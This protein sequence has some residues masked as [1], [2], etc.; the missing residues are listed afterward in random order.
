MQGRPTSETKKVFSHSRGPS[1]GFVATQFIS[2]RLKDIFRID[3]SSCDVVQLTLLK[4]AGI[5]EKPDKCRFDG[6]TN[7]FISKEKL[8]PNYSA[9]ESD[10]VHF[11]LFLSD[12]SMK[13]LLEFL[14]S[15]K[16][17]FHDYTSV[18][19][20]NDR[21]AN[22]KVFSI[23]YAGFE[24]TL[25]SEIVKYLREHKEAVDEHLD[26]MNKN[27]GT[28]TCYEYTRSPKSGIYNQEIFIPSEKICFNKNRAY[29]AEK[30][31]NK[32]DGYFESH[33]ILKRVSLPN[34]WVDKLKNEL[35]G[36]DA[37]ELKESEADIFFDPILILDFYALEDKF[38]ERY[39]QF[40]TF[41][42]PNYIMRYFEDENNVNVHSSTATR[43][44]ELINTLDPTE[45]QSLAT[46]LEERIINIKKLDERN[47]N[48]TSA[49]PITLPTGVAAVAV[50]AVTGLLLESVPASIFAGGLV[51]FGKKKYDE[52]F[53]NQCEEYRNKIFGALSMKPR[54]YA[55]PYDEWLP[56]HQSRRPS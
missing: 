55:T 31:D 16:I 19:S 30:P 5:E 41:I 4:L 43:I 42:L 53:K 51:L 20:D 15:K 3:T 56:Q 34:K 47:K 8:E 21:K 33:T 38:E 35:K 12:G 11:K 32:D 7:P 54:P 26:A 10:F 44:L 23:H 50:S 1:K 37:I 9:S 46:C 22:I 29:T 17:Q 40:G 49:F 39:Y 27:T 18:L 13:Q 45:K 52:Y 36:N 25:C 48:K 28:V 2:N 24:D 14:A 6:G